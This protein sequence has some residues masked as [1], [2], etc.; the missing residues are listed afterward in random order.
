MLILVILVFCILAT[1]CYRER[2]RFFKPNLIP[3][4]ISHTAF[5]IDLKEVSLVTLNENSTDVF[6][7]DFYLKTNDLKRLVLKQVDEKTILD[8]FKSIWNNRNSRSIFHYSALGNISE[9]V[10]Y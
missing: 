6:H 3:L 2:F 8:I 10:P 1:F 9:V 4:E 7:L 5:T